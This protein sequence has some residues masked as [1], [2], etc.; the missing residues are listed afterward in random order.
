[1]PQNTDI[2]TPTVHLQ[3]VGRVPAAPAHQLKVGDQMMYNHGGVFQITRIDDISPKFFR[4]FEVSAETGEEHNRRVKKDSLVARVP[5]AHRRRLGHDAP[6]TDYR[7]QVF[8]PQGKIWITVGHGATLEDATQGY[9]A[10]Y[11]SSSILRDHGLGGSYDA[12]KASVKAMADGKTLTATDGH[13]F[14]I[15]TPTRPPQKP[16]A[17]AAAPA[18]AP[19]DAS[20]PV[21]EFP[22]ATGA[23]YVPEEG[24]QHRDI[25][26]VLSEPDTDN[27]VQAHSVKHSRPIRVPLAMLQPLPELPP[28]PEGEITDWWTI[29][30]AEGAELARVKATDDP[31]ARKAAMRN[32]KVVVASRQDAGFAV[33]RL[34]TSELSVPLGQLR[35]LPRITP[36]EPQITVTTGY[37]RKTIP[38]RL[39]ESGAPGRSAHSEKAGALRWRLP[40][41]EELTYT[42][43][44]HR[45]LND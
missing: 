35:G 40:D 28:D 31:R 17:P 12:N 15:L 26:V 7:A 43:A 22:P 30:D 42:E 24:E 25:V 38:T 16:A 14:R 19:G 34:R 20:E 6:T 21:N 27:T 44:A 37:T 39:R 4:I 36:A 29:L 5:E 1:M 9:K 3:S 23:V 33:R 41:G 11:F 45:F 2:A 13:R 18:A 10:A 32:P 8:A